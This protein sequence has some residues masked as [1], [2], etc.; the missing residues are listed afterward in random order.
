MGFP[1]ITREVP[2]PLHI[3]DELKEVILAKHDGEN[4]KPLKP[5]LVA[6]VAMVEAD[7]KA[8]TSVILMIVLADD[9]VVVAYIT[10]LLPE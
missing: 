6:A 2:V 7:E 10:G 4:C 5:V 8:P 3:A 9:A 1:L